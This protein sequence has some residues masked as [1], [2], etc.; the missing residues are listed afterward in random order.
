M[1][2]PASTPQKTP[3]CILVVEDDVLVRVVIAD[4][5]RAQDF[6]VIEAATADQALSYFQAGIQVDLVLSDIEMPGSMNGLGL[7][8]H[9]RAQAPHLPTVLTS[10]IPPGVHDA[11]AFLAK[12]YDMDQLVALIGRLL[13]KETR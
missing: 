5:L 1:I 2:A 6:L 12:P 10:G 8:H 11:D 3:A 9:L 13:H 7:I 4:E